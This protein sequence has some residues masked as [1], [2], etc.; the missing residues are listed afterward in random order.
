MKGFKLQNES[1]SLI[2]RLT[3]LLTL[4]LGAATSAW[5]ETLTVDKGVSGYNNTTT[6]N[7]P[8]NG[9]QISSS[10]VKAEFIIPK[11][12]LSDMASKRITN[13][14]F[15]LVTATTTWGEAEFQ[16][17]LK[18][19]TISEYNK[20]PVLS[21]TDG[22][23]IVYEGSL[24]PTGTAINIDFTTNFEYSGNND[25]LVGVY[26]TKCGT[27]ANV[28]FK[29]W[30]DSYFYYA[31][32]SKDSSGNPTLTR[33]YLYP[34]TIFTYES[35]AVATLSIDPDEDAAFGTVWAS[36][37]KEYTITNNSGETVNVV[38]ALSGTNAS[39]F[40]VAPSSRNIA[41][42]STATFTLNYSYDSGSLGEKTASI[43]FT[44]DE[45]SSNAITKD[46]TVNAVSNFTISTTDGAFGNVT[47]DANKVYTITNHTGET[48]KVTPGITGTNADMFSVSPSD[49]TEIADGESQDFTVTFDWQ[50]DVAKLG[51]KTATITF[52]LD[53]DEDPFV[54]S[55][56]ATAKTDV[57]LDEDNS[58]YTYGSSKSVLV[59]YTPKNGWN[60]ICMPIFIKTYM[61]S[62][63]GTGWKAYKLESYE[64]GTLTFSKESNPTT[65]EPYLVYIETA[66]GGPFV[67]ES[68]SVSSMEAKGKT[69]D[70]SDVTFQGTYAPMAAGTLTGYYGVTGD[71]HIAKAGSGAYMKGYRAYFTGIDAAEVRM[72]VLE[73]DGGETDL[74]FVKMV[75]DKAKDVYTLTGQK[76][77]KGR[78]G[79]YIVN[80]K[81]V[82]IK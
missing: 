7:L 64:D 43:T 34:V 63:F 56:S 58:G 74:G 21:G 27:N 36:D 38:A 8:I 9:G 13:M 48:V 71:G 26:C 10:L 79:I 65:A 81:K 80:G 22:A 14:A 33:N 29:L 69:P 44:P 41:A 60:T 59:K 11:E 5:A 45:D 28:Q 53:N 75:D 78:K 16:V 42:G 25:L 17:F 49:E 52:T 31:A 24:D 47:A 46:I 61:N 18:E 40:S 12:K 37:S 67:I 68:Y 23:T 51:D 55:A 82:V 3:L 39:S 66:T 72:M 15:Q 50:A 73:D 77:H 20:T 57:V 19:V 70:G 54:I 76:V 62:I 4:L 6:A 30:R 35:P 2:T 1:R 32:Y